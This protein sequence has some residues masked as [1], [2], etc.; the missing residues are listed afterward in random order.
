VKDDQS[1]NGSV[2]LGYARVSK[3]DEQNNLLQARALRAAGCGRL[4]EEVASG[5]RWDRPE[6]WPVEHRRP[7]LTGS[8]LSAPPGSG[9]TYA[10]K[11]FVERLLDMTALPDSDRCA[12]R[13]RITSRS[14]ST[15]P[16]WHSRITASRS[17]HGRAR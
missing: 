2:L 15:I 9:K 1:A 5:G 11:G 17:S 16:V 3:G 6:P 8:R 10:V 4:F 13:C 14:N 12:R 7:Q